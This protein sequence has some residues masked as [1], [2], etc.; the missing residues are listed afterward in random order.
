MRTTSPLADRPEGHPAAAQDGTVDGGSSSDDDDVSHQGNGEE[1][2]EEDDEEAASDQ[3]LAMIEAAARS[4]GIPVEWVLQSL[5]ERGMIAESSADDEDVEYP[6]DNV[7]T[8]L[9][10]VAEFIQ[11]DQCQNILVLAGAGMSVASGIPDFRS[12]NGLYAT[13]DANNLTATEEERDAIR[14]D[15]S[16]ALDQH[17]FLQNPLPCLEL[18]REFLLGTR[19]ERW[20]ATL[21]HRFLELLHFK[22]NK[23]V[24]HYTQ[25]IDGEQN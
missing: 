5:H 16:F 2:Q 21:A 22:T 1:D 24:R 10:E 17:L 11:S 25:N 14:A 7:P 20:K 12:P 19:A 9:K 8:T 13:L 15:P 4:Q 6:F 18:Q 3:L 23:L